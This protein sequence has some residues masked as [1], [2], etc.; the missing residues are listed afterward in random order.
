MW[1]LWPAEQNK[2]C[3]TI[4]SSLS[5]VRVGTRIDEGV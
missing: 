4:L 3:V 2:S 5:Q 1:D